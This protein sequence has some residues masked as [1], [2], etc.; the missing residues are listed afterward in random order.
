M[1]QKSKLECIFVPQKWW[2]YW[3]ICIVSGVLAHVRMMEIWQLYI[4]LYCGGAVI[5]FCEEIFGEKRFEINKLK[6]KIN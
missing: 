5:Y 3:K 1:Y 6:K 2:Y 4:I